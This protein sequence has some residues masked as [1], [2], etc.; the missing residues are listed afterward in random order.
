MKSKT[1]LKEFIKQHAEIKLLKPVSDPN[2]RVDPD[3]EEIVRYDGEMVRITAKENPTLG[4]KFVKLKD[5]F[6][7]C[8]MG[9]G[10]VIAN[11]IIERRLAFT[12]Q[13]HWRTRCA[14]CNKYLGPDGKSIINSSS[15]AQQSYIR[16]FK[17]IK[18]EE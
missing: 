4:F 17:Q 13:K 14:T 6:A 15:G 10:E 12:P 1:Q 3:N 7:V 9:C 11:Q 16:Y 18:Q 8:E 5:K 2:I